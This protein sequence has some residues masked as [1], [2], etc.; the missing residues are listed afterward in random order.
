MYFEIERKSKSKAGGRVVAAAAEDPVGAGGTTL[1]AITLFMKYSESRGRRVRFGE[2]KST[3]TK[4]SF[5]LEAHI[6]ELIIE[7]STKKTN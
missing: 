4:P 6:K 3:C 2:E 7:L 5:D 1:S